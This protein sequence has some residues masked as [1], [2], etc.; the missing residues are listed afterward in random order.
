MHVRTAV[1]VGEQG[2]AM[3][4]EQD[5]DDARSHHWVAYAPTPS[6]PPRPRDGEDALPGPG[7]DGGAA[8]A[9]ARRPVGVIRAVPPDPPRSGALGGVAAD[10][11]GPPTAAAEEEWPPHPTVHAG[12][13]YVRLG[14]LATLPEYRGKGFA[15]LLVETVLDFLRE[16]GTVAEIMPQVGT[17]KPERR[18][19]T[20]EADEALPLWKGLVVVHAQR[21]RS[22]EFWQRYGFVVDEG[23][24]EWDEEGMMH[25][26]MWKRIEL[27]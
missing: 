27:R 17:V 19:L 23:M 9:G 4:R 12:E 5:A 18:K 13:A 6:P 1:F 14:R 15:G 8:S 11:A 24:G 7:L 16:P 3:S 25:V 21:A 2:V 26:G 10:E 22:V 20:G